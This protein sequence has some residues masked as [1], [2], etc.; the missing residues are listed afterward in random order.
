MV[1]RQARPHPGDEVTL[2]TVRGLCPSRVKCFRAWPPAQPP[3]GPVAAA[4]RGGGG[5]LGAKL[6]RRGPSPVESLRGR[7]A[8]V[9][10]LSI[11]A[12]P[13]ARPAHLIDRLGLGFIRHRRR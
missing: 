2:V 7:G 6:R 13:H 12:I 1:R 5:A 4:E 9:Y 3:D 8:E 11:G 10:A